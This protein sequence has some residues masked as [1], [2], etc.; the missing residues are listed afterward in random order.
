MPA[1]NKATA[2]DLQQLI[3]GMENQILTIEGATQALSYHPTINDDTGLC[4]LSYQLIDHHAQIK[5]TWNQAYELVN[6]LVQEG[7]NND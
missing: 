7:R 2:Q 5:K 6:K 4:Y 1:S 3:F